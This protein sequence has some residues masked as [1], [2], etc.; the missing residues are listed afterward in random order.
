MSPASPPRLSDV[1]S[2]WERHPVAA[3]AVPHPIGSPEYFRCYD[4]LRE[5]NES[6]EFSARL[7]EYAGFTGRAVLD[8]GSGNGYVLERYARCGARTVGVDLTSAGASLC[9]RRFA[10]AGLPGSFVQASA[11]SLPFPATVFDAVCSMGVI[12]HT[13]R[14][15]RAFAE[16]RR[17]LRPSGRLILMLYHRDSILYRLRFPAMKLLRGWSIA[18]QVDEVDGS[19]N[20]KGDVYSAGEIRTALEGFT[21]VETW[22]GLLQRWMLPPPLHRLV[23]ARFLR[24]LE[25]RFGWFLYVKARRS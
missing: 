15:E 8:V 21:D 3:A 25:R 2:F 13:P 10:L 18:R 14:P 23:P 7:H 11:E 22:A 4:E 9:R 5:A 24:P 1:R 17:V 20:P 6:P 16:L 19:G 12:H